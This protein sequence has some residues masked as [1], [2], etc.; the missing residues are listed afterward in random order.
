MTEEVRKAKFGIVYIFTGAYAPKVDHGAKSSEKALFI[1]LFQR[2]GPSASK[3][4]GLISQKASD[5]LNFMKR[6]KTSAMYFGWISVIDSH[7]YAE[8]HR[9]TL[10]YD[11][12]KS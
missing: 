7:H 11:P 3:A 1:E 5:R 2:S 6:E 10:T 12:E 4:S 9:T 8:S